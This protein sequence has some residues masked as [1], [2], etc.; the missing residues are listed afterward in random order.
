MLYNI[1]KALTTVYFESTTNDNTR[2]TNRESGLVQIWS[3]KL[4]L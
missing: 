1:L 4:V 3:Y 2:K